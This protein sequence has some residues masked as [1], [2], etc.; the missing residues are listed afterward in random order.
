MVGIKCLDGIILGAEK[1]VFS[2]LLVEGTNKRIYNV[3][4]TIGCVLGGRVPDGRNVMT[5][6]RQESSEY[7]K[8]FS[9]MGI[10]CGCHGRITL[11]DM[12]TIEKSNLNQLYLHLFYNKLFS[13]FLL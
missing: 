12:D 2:K 9:M 8:Q 7:L 10:G 6:A 3:D 4:N 1:L 13:L 11:T 5:R